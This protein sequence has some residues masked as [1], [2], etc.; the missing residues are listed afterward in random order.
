MTRPSGRGTTVQAAHLSCT[1][2]RSVQ[3]QGIQLY[4]TDYCIVRSCDLCVRCVCAAATPARR[5]GGQGQGAG[6]CR[7]GRA[8][9]ERRETESAR[10]RA[11]RARPTD[12]EDTR[13]KKSKGRRHLYFAVFTRDS[14]A[15]RR[16]RLAITG[17]RLCPTKAPSLRPR[18]AA[19]P[20]PTATEESHP[21][22]ESQHASTYLSRAGRR[23]ARRAR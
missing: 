1:R 7:R 19:P 2:S 18:L 12:S 11:G 14:R 4:R 23:R 10:A 22:A 3:R 13:Q 8:R 9:G 5:G 16:E 15:G 21:R 20:P 17:A 6:V